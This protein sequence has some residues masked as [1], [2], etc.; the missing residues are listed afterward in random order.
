MAGTAAEIA[1]GIRVRGRLSGSLADGS[2][3]RAETDTVFAVG[4]GGGL[5]EGAGRR[6]G[7]G[8]DVGRASTRRD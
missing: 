4:G 3:I 5:G 1:D 7:G 6:V 2:P 8:L